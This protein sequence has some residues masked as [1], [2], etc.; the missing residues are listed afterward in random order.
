MDSLRHHPTVFHVT[1]WGDDPFSRGAYSTLLPGGTPEH[2]RRLGEVIGGKLML[3]G[4]AC[5]PVAPAMTHGAWNDGLRAAEVAIESGARRV[6]VIGAGFAGLAAARRLREAGIDCVVLEARDRVGGRVHS[7]TLGPVRVDEGAA[8]LQQFDDNPLAAHA[9]H[10]GLPLRETDFGQPLAAAA[11]GPVPDIDAAWEALRAGIDRRLPLA[12]GVTRYLENCDEPTRRATR[13]ALDA[14]LILEACLPLESLSVA[15]LDEEGVGAGD[16][17]L[18]QGYSQLVEQLAAGLDIRLNRP[19]SAIDWS[20]SP[21]RVDDEVADFCICTVPVGVLRDIHFNPPLP[22]AQ[23]TALDHLGMGQLEKVVLQF[24]ERWW[25][26]SPSGYLRWYD[27]PASFGEWLDLTDAVGTPTVA[28]LIAADALERVFAGRSDEEIAHAA[29]K[30]LQAWAD[31][32]RNN[33]ADL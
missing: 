12:D 30:A 11:D 3:A 5:N 6:V 15:A 22:P 4:E 10:L 27:T 21:V 16:R 7:I 24:D 28:G 23:Q 1:H 17:F 18:P 32:I 14:N 2:R 25:P 33:G 31:A 8:W 29:C 20:D 26:V 19:V 9:Q 13:F